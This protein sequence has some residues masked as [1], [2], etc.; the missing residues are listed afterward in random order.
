MRELSLDGFIKVNPSLAEWDEKYFNGMNE[1]QGRFIETE[2]IRFHIHFHRNTKTLR[3]HPK[4]AP[5][6]IRGIIAASQ[7]PLLQRCAKY[8]CVRGKLRAP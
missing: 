3:I 7:A 8:T 5:T 2:H 4:T 6:G 1:N